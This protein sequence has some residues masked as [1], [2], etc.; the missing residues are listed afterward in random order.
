MKQRGWFSR[1]WNPIHLSIRTPH[2]VN[3]S[4]RSRFC[5]SG[6]NVAMFAKCSTVSVV[7]LRTFEPL[8]VEFI[9]HNGFIT[10][11]FHPVGTGVLA[12]ADRGNQFSV[13]EM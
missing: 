9:F 5:S 4:D 7:W 3:Y 12:V 1:R 6:I 10:A 8:N 2:A 13:L 11:T